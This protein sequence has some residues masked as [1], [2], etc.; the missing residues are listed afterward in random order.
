MT[1]ELIE[2]I[3][4]KCPYGQGIFFQPSGIST[5]IKEHV[6]YSRYEVGYKPGSC[7]DDEDTVNEYH[8]QD[9]PQDHFKVLDITLEELGVNLTDIQRR[10]I[11][12]LIK[13]DTDTESGYYGDYQDYK[14]EY[15]I[16]GELES[17]LNTIKDENS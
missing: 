8:E 11:N 10:L 6:I 9:I 15:I 16:L 7:W 12:G 3:N 1:K 17:Y 5:N 14:C 4:A 2:K 13:E